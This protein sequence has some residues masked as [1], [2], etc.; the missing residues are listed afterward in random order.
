MSSAEGYMETI[1]KFKSER[2]ALNPDHERY[3][4]S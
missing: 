2:S 3:F 1:N 4:Y